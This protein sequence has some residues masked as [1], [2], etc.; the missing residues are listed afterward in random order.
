MGGAVVRLALMLLHKWTK[1]RLIVYWAPRSPH[2]EYCLQLPIREGMLSPPAQW[3]HLL[4][5]PIRRAFICFG[6]SGPPEI[7]HC[8]PTGTPLWDVDSKRLSS[9]VQIINFIKQI[10]G[11]EPWFVGTQ[12]KLKIETHTCESQKWHSGTCT[13]NISFLL[14][15]GIL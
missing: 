7:S 5:K 8:Y 15:S 6:C 10:L 2:P 3:R 9:H 14:L 13:Q 1:R 11:Q 12:Q 4:A